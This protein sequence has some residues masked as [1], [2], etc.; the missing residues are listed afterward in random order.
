MK[1]YVV[2]STDGH[3]SV[4]ATE[5]AAKAFVKDWNADSFWRHRADTV[6][7]LVQWSYREFDVQGHSDPHVEDKPKSPKPITKPTLA[8]GS[9]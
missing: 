2:Q 4:F 6:T 7:P 9:R 8:V 5:D 3:V 1:V